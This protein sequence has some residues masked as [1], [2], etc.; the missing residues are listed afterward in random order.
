[1]SWDGGRWGC[2]RRLVG[3]AAAL[4]VREHARIASISR[5]RIQRRRHV[6]TVAFFMAFGP[7]SPFRTYN[8][9]KIDAFMLS[10]IFSLAISRA[11]HRFLDRLEK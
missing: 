9:S 6:S 8:T 1:M 3:A 5:Y 11:H 7:G 4:P 10:I 2:G